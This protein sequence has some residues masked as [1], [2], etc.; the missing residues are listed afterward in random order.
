MNFYLFVPTIHF[1][2]S[3]ES[4]GRVPP[5]S[6]FTEDLDRAAAILDVDEAPDQAKE[7]SNGGDVHKVKHCYKQNKINFLIDLGL[8]S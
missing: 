3:T 6:S 1:Q 5:Y 2:T 7:V 4:A 8:C